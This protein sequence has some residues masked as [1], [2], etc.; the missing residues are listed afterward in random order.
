MTAPVAVDVRPPSLRGKELADMTAAELQAVVYAQRSAM[1][2][3]MAEA[4]K[5][6]SSIHALGMTCEEFSA[7]LDRCGGAR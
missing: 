5:V 2:E 4:R 1:A 7:A 3:L 6:E